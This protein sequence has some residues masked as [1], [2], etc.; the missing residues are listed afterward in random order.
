MIHAFRSSGAD[1]EL[2]Y[3]AVDEIRDMAGRNV[4]YALN[5]LEAKLTGMFQT[6]LAHMKCEIKTQ[7]AE[8]RTNRWMISII[9]VLTIAFGLLKV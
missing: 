1:D 7:A 6:E 3:N 9:L 8:I 5:T 2:I 4:F